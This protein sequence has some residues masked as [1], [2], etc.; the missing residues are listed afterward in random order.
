MAHILIADDAR[1]IRL[2]YEEFLSSKGHIVIT[3]ANGIEA[4]ALMN[5]IDFD[6]IITDMLMPGYDGYELASLAKKL[7][8]CPKILA[9]SG[10]GTRVTAEQLME[11]HEAFFDATLYKPVESSHLLQTINTLIAH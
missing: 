9:I 5:D 6:L 1:D 3:A 2:A 11:S 8:H 10:G 4:A 7:D